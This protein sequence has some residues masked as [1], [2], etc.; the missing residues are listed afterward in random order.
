M[1]AYVTHVTSGSTDEGGG[2]GG[3]PDPAQ[4]MRDMWG[5]AGVDQQV[6]A[7]ITTCWSMM[8]PERPNVDAVAAEVR[9]LVER[10]LANLREDAAAFG[11]AP[12]TT[13]P[14]T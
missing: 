4:A 2:E 7:A 10:A 14:A 9:R 6:R 8:P 3:C 11:F 12:P 5:P 13:A 1:A